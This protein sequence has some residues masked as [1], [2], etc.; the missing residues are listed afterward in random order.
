MDTIIVTRKMVRKAITNQD[1]DGLDFFGDDFSLDELEQAFWTWLQC[2]IFG[3]LLPDMAHWAAGPRGIA[4]DAFQ[5]T[6]E[7]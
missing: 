6:K 1:I 4:T 2:A 7:E 5:P 3:H